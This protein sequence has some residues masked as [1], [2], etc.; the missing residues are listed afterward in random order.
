M[1]YYLDWLH[2]NFLF[3]FV[4]RWT[5]HLSMLIMWCISIHWIFIE[6]RRWCSKGRQINLHWIK[7]FINH[8][9]FCWILFSSSMSK[10][11][12]IKMPWSWIWKELES[13]EF[14]F[15]QALDFSMLIA[16]DHDQWIEEECVDIFSISRTR[17]N[18]FLYNLRSC[19]RKIRCRC[20]CQARHTKHLQKH[21]PSD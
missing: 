13:L 11:T 14:T 21:T 2:S 16:D 9:F 8:I 6:I 19:A 7:L 1:K 5:C 18:I 10:R 12:K 15:F 4:F 3:W 20:R 17:L